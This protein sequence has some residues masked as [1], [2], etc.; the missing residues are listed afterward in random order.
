MTEN[1]MVVVKGSKKGEMGGL[2]F[3]GYRVSIREDEKF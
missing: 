1:R 2:L 3:D